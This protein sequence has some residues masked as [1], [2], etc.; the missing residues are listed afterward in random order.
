M[1]TI[2]SLWFDVLFERAQMLQQR[3]YSRS[4]IVPPAQFDCCWAQSH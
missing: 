3:R 2:E 1:E 4:L